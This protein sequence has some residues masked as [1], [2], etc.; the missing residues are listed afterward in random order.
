[1]SALCL[2]AVLQASLAATG[3]NTYADAHRETTETGKPMVV[4]VGTDWCGPCQQMKKTVIPQVKKRGVMKK[5][6]FAL[7]NADHESTLARKLTGGGPVPQ[8]VMLRTADNGWRR[9]I[10]V[11]GQSVETV[12]KFIKEGVALA[13]AEKEK[14][15]KTDDNA[16]GK[17][18]SKPVKSSVKEQVVKIPDPPEDK[19]SVH[20]VSTR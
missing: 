17:A 12:E 13:E 11:G 10:L 18:A 1:V 20:P 19:V 16:E 5:V 9:R 14:A 15:D 2:A 4:L 3:A 8:L 7:V 6:T